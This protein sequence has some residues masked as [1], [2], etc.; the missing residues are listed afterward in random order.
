VQVARHRDAAQLRVH[1]I[2]ETE[3]WHGS[4]M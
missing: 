1:P 4:Q 2:V 3:V